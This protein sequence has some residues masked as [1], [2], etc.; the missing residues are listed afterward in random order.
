MSSAACFRERKWVTEWQKVRYLDVLSQVTFGGASWARLV[1]GSMAYCYSIPL[2]HLRMVTYGRRE[3]SKHLSDEAS[4]VVTAIRE[5]QSTCDLHPGL[6][7]ARL[8]IFE[9]LT[10]PLLIYKDPCRIN[11]NPRHDDVG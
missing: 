5:S 9:F 3:S 7:A 10:V 2:H 4:C 1:L 8:S 11:G 6:S